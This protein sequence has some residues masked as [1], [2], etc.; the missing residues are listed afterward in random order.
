MAIDQSQ[1]DREERQ[2]LQN[3]LWKYA[4]WATVL[5][6]FTGAGLFIGYQVWGDASRLRQEVE[7][8]TEKMTM[9]EKER[10]TL[11]SQMA[12][13]DRDKKELDKSLQEMKAKCAPTGDAAAAPSGAAGDV[14]IE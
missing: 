5:A 8:L 14:K 13:I 9:R 10:D 3:K 2:E 11:K 4:Q 7:Q 12:I 6:V 1:L